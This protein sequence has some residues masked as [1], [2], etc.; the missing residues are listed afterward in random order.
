MR[1]RQRAVL[2]SHHA[3]LRNV[4][5]GRIPNHLIDAR[6]LTE[7]LHDRKCVRWHV[8]GYNPCDTTGGCLRAGKHDRCLCLQRGLRIERN[9]FG[10][11]SRT[12]HLNEVV[13]RRLV[14]REQSELQGR[15]RNPQHATL[16]CHGMVKMS[17][18]CGL[19]CTRW[20]GTL[21]S[22]EP[23]AASAGTGSPSCSSSPVRLPP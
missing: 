2:C 9:E 5:R 10:A 1:T 6:P 22:A 13:G 12:M 17:H 23:R 19:Q 11:W 16:V 14:E 3:N 7:C 15:Y 8:R 18:R 20:A 21:T 4:E